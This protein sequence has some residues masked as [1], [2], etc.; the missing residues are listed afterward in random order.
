MGEDILWTTSRTPI[1]HWTP[2]HRFV[3]IK[4][5]NLPS[6]R[7]TLED[8]Y[9]LT[10]TKPST[11]STHPCATI[12]NNGRCSHLCVATGL[13]TSAC[14]CSP[15]TELSDAS[16]I[17]C[18]PVPDCFFRCGSGECV[19]EAQK[20]DGHKNCADSSDEVQCQPKCHQNQVECQ[21]G[22]CIVSNSLNTNEFKVGNIVQYPYPIQN[23][24]TVQYP[25]P[26]QNG[27]VVPVQ[28]IPIPQSAQNSIND[29]LNTVNQGVNQY[30][31]Y[32]YNSYKNENQNNGV[33][34]I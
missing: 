26:V 5:T 8:S 15:G 32:I 7:Y 23:G 9:V 4:K 31:S 22:K 30:L 33:P 11:V 34:R 18:F 28:A 2:T 16:N 3:G 12:G 19:T 20:C 17:T 27:I 25:H 6:S 1:L 14:L 10:A 24:M 13:T 29:Y 21:N